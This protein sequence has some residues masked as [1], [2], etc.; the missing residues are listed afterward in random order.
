MLQTEIVVAV[1][2]R[3]TKKMNGLFFFGTVFFFS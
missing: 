3:F 2:R 1:V